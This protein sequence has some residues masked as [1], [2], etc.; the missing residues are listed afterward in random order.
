M[1]NNAERADMRNAEAEYSQGPEAEEK[2]EVIQM[3]E[4]I[5][6]LNAKLRENA[7]IKGEIKDP[8][9]RELADRLENEDLERVAA[10]EEELK[11]AA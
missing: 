9:I 5:A 2:S 3:K 11:K 7:R 1:G 10:L 8:K 6:A 4:T